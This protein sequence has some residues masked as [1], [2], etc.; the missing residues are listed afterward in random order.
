[1]KIVIVE[2]HAIVRGAIRQACSGVAKCRV[3]GETDSGAAAVKM[4]HAIRPDAVILDLGLA[5]LDGFTVAECVRYAL[6]D[7]K[8][9]VLSGR[10]DDY[11]VH[12]LDQLGLHG[13]LDK[14]SIDLNRV[15][16]ALM[17]LVAGRT[18]F[19]VAFRAFK[20]RQNAHPCA[21]AKLLSEAEQRVLSL[22]GHGMNNDE[23][24]FELGISPMTAQKHRSSLLHKLALK[25]TPKLIAYATQH[26]FSHG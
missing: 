11:T 1:M 21:F 13:F 3:V 19:S 23:I 18:Y 24:G 25:G 12:R 20:G 16:E 10:L 2:D 14:A 22:I 7:V 6:P 15:Q 5:D 9:L 8:I 4:I 26:G 17:A